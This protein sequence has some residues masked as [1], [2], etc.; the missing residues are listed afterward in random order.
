MSEVTHRINGART[1]R[2]LIFSQRIRRTIKKEKQGNTTILTKRKI[3]EV[4]HRTNGIRTI[5]KKSINGTEGTRIQTTLGN[6]LGRRLRRAVSY[7]RHFYR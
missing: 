6:G 4:D 5:K 7:K 2:I 3:S 1:S